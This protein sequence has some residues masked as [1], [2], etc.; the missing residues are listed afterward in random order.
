MDAIASF[1]FVSAHTHRKASVLQS[2]SDSSGSV[3]STIPTKHSDKSA[4][5]EMAQ[6][7]TLKL[8]LPSQNFVERQTS[9]S[10]VFVTVSSFGPAFLVPQQHVSYTVIFA[11][12]EVGV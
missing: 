11:F 7:D 2:D 6:V 12:V 10:Q 8:L 1:T 9:S 3:D 5:R 4:L